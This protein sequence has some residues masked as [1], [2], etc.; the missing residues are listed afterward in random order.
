M[1]DEKKQEGKPRDPRHPRE[2]KRQ[3]LPDQAREAALESAAA[4]L[5]AIHMGKQVGAELRAAGRAS[6]G[7]QG[8]RLPRDLRVPVG[9]VLFG[10][11][12]IQ[13]D[14][15]RRLFEFNRD[16]T[17]LLR[18]RLRKSIARPEARETITR[19]GADRKTLR[20]TIKNTASLS[21]T[22]TF[23][24]EVDDDPGRRKPAKLEKTSVTI[25]A[26]CSSDVEVRFDRALEDGTYSGD[27]A[28]M[29]QGLDVELIPFVIR[30][31]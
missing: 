27:I 2:R 17:T 6:M 9:D 23:R 28:V 12:Q 22:F 10:V 3:A 18:D 21:R 31:P 7:A 5:A 11:A 24:A 13:V 19:I 14:F 25:A 29:S 4:T 26:G 8:D 15:A 20:F 30:L 1:A 16:A